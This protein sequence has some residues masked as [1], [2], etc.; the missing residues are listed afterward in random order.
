MN[1]IHS[2]SSPLHMLS[3]LTDIRPAQHLAEEA[4]PA[5]VSCSPP[6]TANVDQPTPTPENDQ[7]ST[8]DMVKEN[9]MNS[10]WTS[11]CGRTQDYEAVDNAPSQ[12]LHLKCLLCF[13]LTRPEVF[14][15]CTY[16][17]PMMAYMI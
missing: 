7:G 14:T 1:T 17:P 9:A 6:S 13:P 10:E 16:S 2:I 11:H 8:L 4:I 12:Y 3:S 5:L 15:R